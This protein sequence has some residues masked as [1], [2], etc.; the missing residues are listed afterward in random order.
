MTEKK[1]KEVNI[2]YMDEMVVA[3]EMQ[4]TLSFELEHKSLRL[5][6][7][8]NSLIMFYMALIF[9]DTENFH[10][11]VPKSAQNVFLMY[12]GAMYFCLSLY[13]IRAAKKGVLDSFSQWQKGNMKEGGKPF[14]I[15]IGYMNAFLP[16]MQILNYI[17]NDNG[18]REILA[19]YMTFFIIWF[20][21]AIVW[22]GIGAYS[23]ALNKKVRES[24][25]ADEENEEE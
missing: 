6:Y 10:E 16:F 7:I 3:D 1:K 20:I 9:S 12:L 17:D 22:Y 14:M 18:K 23:V 13:N 19:P 24:L 11:A 21:M 4:K 25:A 8:F 2:D 15:L 5:W